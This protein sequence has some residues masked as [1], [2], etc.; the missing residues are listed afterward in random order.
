MNFF[1]DSAGDITYVSITIHKSKLIVNMN[2]VNKLYEHSEYAEA[3][4][5]LKNYFKDSKIDYI[6]EYIIDNLKHMGI[7]VIIVE[8]KKED[9]NQQLSLF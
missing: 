8:D 2:G 6:R 7:K 3:L 5:D 4:L 9:N 1:T